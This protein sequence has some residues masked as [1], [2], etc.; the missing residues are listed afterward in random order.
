MSLRRRVL[1]LAVLW[2]VV[3]GAVALVPGCF[4]QNCNQTYQL[5][6]RDAGEGRLVD[7]NTWESN[8]AEGR[9]LPFPHQRLWEFDLHELGDREPRVVIPYLSGNPEPNRTNDTS[10]IA[11]GNIAEISGQTKGRVFIHNGTCA[12]Y[13]LR[14]VVVAAPRAPELDGGDAAA[15]D[16]GDA[17]EDAADAGEDAPSDAADAGD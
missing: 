17:G 12:D 4:A 1:L 6:G 7:E 14:I 10:V 16:A 2:A 8:P 9:W 13:F 3:T 15:D 11:T 5:W